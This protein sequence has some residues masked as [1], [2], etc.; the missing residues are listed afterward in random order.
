LQIAM[1]RWGCLLRWQIHRPEHQELRIPSQ[2]SPNLDRLI[3]EYLRVRPELGVWK[4]LDDLPFN[5]PN[6]T[7]VEHSYTIPSGI[8]VWVL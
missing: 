7:N 5:T 1:R 3:A 8:R 4:V 6:G 2:K